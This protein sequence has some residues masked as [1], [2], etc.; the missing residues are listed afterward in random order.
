[1]AKAILASSYP[2]LVIRVNALY[3]IGS[4]LPGPSASDM[5]S[6]MD[7]GGITP[8]RPSTVRKTV[9]GFPFNI[10]FNDLVILASGLPTYINAS[11]PS[12]RFIEYTP[13]PTL[14]GLMTGGVAE[15]ALATE[16]VEARIESGAPVWISTPY[17]FNK[18]NNMIIASTSSVR[19]NILLELKPLLPPGPKYFGDSAS[20]LYAGLSIRSLCARLSRP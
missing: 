2:P 8:S 11:V 1:M 15:A 12:G 3:K 4:T 19:I 7:S 14:L 9:T 5:P 6:C 13:R 16:F 17:F 20:L 18:G 10:A